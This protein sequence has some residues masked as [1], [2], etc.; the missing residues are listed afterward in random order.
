LRTSPPE[1]GL[2]SFQLTSSK[3]EAASHQQMVQFLE[4]QGLMARTLVDP[5]CVR[6]CVH[7]FSL[8][9][10]IDQLVAGIQQFCQMKGF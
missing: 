10:E 4:T 2:V 3:R 5:D 8:E 1:S 6:A 7:Y 9:S